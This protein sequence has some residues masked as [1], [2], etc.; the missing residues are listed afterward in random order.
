MVMIFGGALFGT[1]G[2][3]VLLALLA[4]YLIWLCGELR[5]QQVRFERLG[6]L[7]PLACVDL[8]VARTRLAKSQTQRLRAEQAQR[9]KTQRIPGAPAPAGPLRLRARARTR[10]G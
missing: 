9:L 1:A 4:A 3:A 5:R 7:P 6:R 10:A 8:N 2:V